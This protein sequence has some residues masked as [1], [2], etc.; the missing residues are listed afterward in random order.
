M[1]QDMIQ[2]I[3]KIRG[4]GNYR[5][6]IWNPTLLDDFKRFNLIY[7]WNYSGKTTLSRV[8]QSFGQAGL[9]PDFAAA[10]LEVTVECGETFTTENLYELPTACVFNRDFIEQNF[11]QEHQAPAV[12]IVG[13]DTIH[14]KK[15]QAV[16]GNRVRRVEAYLQI[17]NPQLTAAKDQLSTAGTDQARLISEIL[18]ERSFRRPILD[19]VVAEIRH[20][21]SDFILTDPEVD[22][23]RDTYRS[24]EQF[25]S[26]GRSPEIE[27]KLG[28]LI[29][30]AK[31]LLGQTAS[32]QAIESLANNPVL[33]KWVEAGCELHGHSKECL[34]CG[35]SVSENRLAELRNHFSESYQRLTGELTRFKE[36]LGPFLFTFAPTDP[37]NVMPDLRLRYETGIAKL[38]AWI[39]KVEAIQDTLAAIIDKKLR[40]IES[41]LEMPDVELPVPSITEVISEINSVIDQHNERVANLIQA[42]IDIREKLVK[43]YAATFFLDQDVAQKEAAIKA[44]EV[45]VARAVALKEKIQAWIQRIEEEIKG[46]SVGAGRLNELLASILVGND[47]SVVDRGD[48]TFEFRRGESLAKNLSDG[49]RTAVSFAYFMVSLEE[50]EAGISDQIIFIDDPICSLD[51][52][53]IYAVYA[54]IREKLM[55]CKQLFVSTHNSEFFNLIRDAWIGHRSVRGAVNNTSCYLVTRVLGEDRNTSSTISRLPEL[56]RKFKS[57]YQF[58]FSQLKQFAENPTP[59]MHEAYTAPNLVRKFFEAY[60]GFR[61]PGSGS[62]S[63]KLDLVIDD[64]AVRRE[65]QKFA[66]DSSHL[67][68]PARATQHPDYISNSQIIVRTV[69]DSISQKDPDHYQSLCSVCA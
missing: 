68:S 6:F 52:N 57:E 56:L 48:G 38:H 43:H 33:E 24:A 1:S 22:A 29:E 67:Q 59:S 49:E 62:W 21:P 35:N 16:L 10:N 14:L 7:G 53:H 2:R 12:F 19:E 18:G 36:K 39:S 51:S 17:K 31:I 5:D 63:E 28:D 32:N 4:F 60:I 26:V 44:I 55:G 30:T 37:A 15:R 13:G 27:S 40:S 46:S 66:D 25:R 45:R 64:V 9:H 34:Y 50:G 54:L 69:I 65:V 61:R 42:K 11:A 23:L 58:V 41:A 8:I 3:D 47:I 20:N